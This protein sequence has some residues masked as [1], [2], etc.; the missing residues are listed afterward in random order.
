MPGRTAVLK[1]GALLSL[2]LFVLLLGGC[3]KQE[4][5]Q[6][7]AEEILVGFAQIGSES[8][9]RIG[10]TRDMEE[11]AV[12][13]GVRLMMEDA[14]Q[15]QENEIRALRSFIAY[16]VDVITFVPIVEDG[17]TN[18]LQEAKQAG[19]PVIL[20]DRLVSEDVDPDL[21]S[22]Y[23]GADFTQEGRNAGTFL[24]KKAEEMEGET[25]GIVEL[26]GTKDSSPAIQREIGFHEVIDG[27]ARFV[28]LDQMSGDF[29][30]SKGRECMEQLIE[31]YGDQIDILYSHNDAMTYGA[32]EAMEA[33]GIVP[34]R[35]IVII[36]VDGE[37]EAIDLL[38]EGKINC[39]VECTPMLG[40]LVFDIAKRL[41]AGETVPKMT[42]PKEAVF[43]EYDDLSDLPPRGY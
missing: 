3:Q 15:K 37:Q 8:G 28:M 17:W 10:N 29:L 33:V 14:N 34:G 27:N 19:I 7:D 42:S 13:N 18:V 6:N 23:I 41:A 43:T 2:L 26:T 25:L 22:A 36:S 9:W 30:R 38:R 35:D 5:P 39:V 11:A 21:Y 16:N 40:D 20:S 4:E 12:R 32:I 1:W 31:R 24:L